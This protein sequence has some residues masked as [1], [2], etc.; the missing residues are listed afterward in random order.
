MTHQ[1]RSIVVVT[2][3]FFINSTV[4]AEIKTAVFGG[5]CFWCVEADFDKI[6]GVLKTT[7]G[8]A[9]GQYKNP[10]YKAVSS[11]RTDHVEVVEI[12]YDDTKVSYSQLIEF[13]WK[14]IDPTAKDRQF[15]DSGR[16]YRTGFYYLN[17]EQ[18][19]AAQTAKEKLQTSGKFKTIYTE[20]A[21][22]VVFY[23]AEEYHQ[24]YYIK[25]PIR[26]RYYRNACGRDKRL[27]EIWGTQRSAP[28]APQ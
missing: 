25:N 22:A 12:T 26:Y 15:C 8:Y 19:T 5:G 21:P 4:Q 9:G 10:D 13:F 17:N 2:L 24:D 6:E 3:G 7:S 18:K 11:G 16:Q 1:L 28:T 23:A 14:T 20:V 27:D